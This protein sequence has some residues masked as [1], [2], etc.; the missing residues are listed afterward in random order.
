[1]PAS[2]KLILNDFASAASNDFA[3]FGNQQAAQS[4]SYYYFESNCVS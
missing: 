1:M 3:N 4:G 2:L